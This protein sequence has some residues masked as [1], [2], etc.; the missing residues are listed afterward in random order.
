MAEEL[1]HNRDQRRFEAWVDGEL[2]GEMTYALQG[3]VANFNHTYVADSARGTGLAGRLAQFAFDQVRADGQW[4]I[5]PTCPY[6]I[7]WAKRHR[8]YADLL[9]ESAR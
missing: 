6:V 1:R 7:A 8:E 4:T 5:L 2:T 3:D 9:V